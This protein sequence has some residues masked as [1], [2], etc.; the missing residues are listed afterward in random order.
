VTAVAESGNGW[1]TVRLS[2]LTADAI[3][4]LWG[5]PPSST[6][7]DEVDVLVIRAADFRGWDTRR[8]KDAASRRVP[9]RSLARRQLGE[10][11]LVL[12]V[13]GGSPS[14]PVGRVLLIDHETLGTGAIPM[15]CSNFCRRLRLSEKAEPEF[16]KLQLDW[17]YSMGHAERFQTSTTNIRNLQVDDF[18]NGTL[19]SLPSRPEQER[20]VECLRAVRARRFN[21]Q[22]HVA[23]ARKA[24][25]R[26]RRAVL[27]AACSGL[28]T[29]EWREQNGYLSAPHL[30]TEARKRSKQFRHIDSYDLDELPDGWT[31]AQVD[32][33]LPKGG[34]FDGPFG[35]NLKTSDYTD[36]GAR[37]VRL[38]NIGHLRF[39]GEKH[40]YVSLEK[41]RQ[42]VKHA[43]G[44]GD[45]MFSSFV[46]DEMR[47]CVLPPDVGTPTI[48]KAD[49]FTLRPIDKVDRD[50]LALQLASPATFKALSND[51][52]GATRPRVNTTQLRSV[53]VPLCSVEEQR[54]VVSRYQSAVGI[55][56]ALEQ[57]L[58][59]AGGRLR[60]S[61]QAVLAKAFR[62]ELM[63]IGARH[64]LN[65][66]QAAEG[67]P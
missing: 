45:I 48:A 65:V 25:Q 33:L 43:V 64:D 56:D 28:L 34:I 30:D 53:P 18:L 31:W 11:D 27:A 9:E 12:E 7:S 13:S 60:L 15:I 37:V 55:I 3:G 26:F 35:S 39:I 20:I 1:E 29:A 22:Q 19:L 17:L 59:A 40:T 5:N 38:E 54:E 52:H 32:D 10:G 51:V 23:L 4:G 62:G 42:L 61:S 6:K 50:Y 47:V 46:D 2:D 41:Y 24:T 57:R 44:P 66:G 14:Q 67:T 36:A 49:C 8:A 58:E 16:V 63:P 21:A